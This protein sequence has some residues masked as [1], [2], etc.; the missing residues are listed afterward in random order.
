MHQTGAWFKHPDAITSPHHNS[1]LKEPAMSTLRLILPLA[2]PLAALRLSRL[3]A[4]I[5]GR[6]ALARSRRGLRRLDDHLLRDIG[7]TR[8]EAEA[9][10]TRA[11]WDAP[12]HWRG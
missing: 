11:V 9:E 8:Q 6:I 2:R 4:L 3:R 5:A 12:S 10:A 1:C 7:L